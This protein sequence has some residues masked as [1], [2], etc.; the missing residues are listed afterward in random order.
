ME[1]FEYLLRFLEK[2]KMNRVLKEGM[3]VLIIKK[4]YNQNNDYQEKFFALFK[5]K[6]EKS[7][8]FLI[9]MY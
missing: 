6:K 1:L 4:F 8:E 7:Q 9:L 2:N 3:F 5:E